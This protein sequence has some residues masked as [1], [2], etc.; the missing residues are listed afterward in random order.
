MKL[1]SRGSVE[2]EAWETRSRLKL[3]EAALRCGIDSRYYKKIK[4]GARR[5]G[6]IVALRIR[7]AAGIA[8]EAWDQP[9]ETEE[10]RRAS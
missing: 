4:M 2:L 7:A 3:S 1:L 9:S 8:I 10:E 6:R 5:P